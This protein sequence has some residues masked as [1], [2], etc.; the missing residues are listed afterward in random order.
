M[1]FIR[2]L[3]VISLLCMVAW[4]LRIEHEQLHPGSQGTTVGSVLQQAAK[5]HLPHVEAAGESEQIYFA[6]AT[7]LQKVDISLIDQAQQ[8]IP[9]A[10]YAFTDRT[11]A[12]ALARA[13]ARGVEVSIYRDRAQ[14]EEE[15]GRHVQVLALLAHRPNVHIRVKGS[16]DLMHQKAMLV[17]GA[18][19][20]DGS[21]N[22]SVSAARYQ[23]N[24]V[25]VTQNPQQIEAFERDFAAMW[26]RPDNLLEQ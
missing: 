6:P 13:A 3:F 11:I 23:D 16:D 12:L 1:R 19:L 9:V 20:R 8:R 21:G 5:L 10:M 2:R 25:S 7:D 18:V 15:Q 22:W 4:K 24:Q 17:D 14:F 26:S